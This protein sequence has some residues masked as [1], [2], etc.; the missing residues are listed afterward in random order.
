MDGI[1]SVSDTRRCRTSRRGARRPSGRASG[2]RSRTGSQSRR[3]PPCARTKPTGSAPARS[4]ARR[5]VYATGSPIPS[6]KISPPLA[7]APAVVT[8]LPA[9]GIVAKQRVMSLHVTVIGPPSRIP[10]A[11]AKNRKPQPN[12]EQAFKGAPRDPLSTPSGNGGIRIRKHPPEPRSKHPETGVR[13]AQIRRPEP[14]HWDP[15]PNEA[16]THILRTLGKPP[17]RA[18]TAPPRCCIIV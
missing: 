1:S 18:F 10:F 9:S 15:F 2:R 16:E 13:T 12:R 7:S 14:L 6:T 17:C 3:Q 4:A 8:R 5:I 11:K